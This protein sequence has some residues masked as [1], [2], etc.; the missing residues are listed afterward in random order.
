MKLKNIR[1]MK[2]VKGSVLLTVICVM[3][4]MLIIVTAT[5][6][7]AANASNRAYTSYMKNQATYT[8]RSAVNATIAKLSSDPNGAMS[9]EII[10]LLKSGPVELTVSDVSGGFGN[11]DRIVI[12][13]TGKLDDETGFYITGSKEKIYK[14]TAH[15][16]I[17][18]KEQTFSQYVT[19]KDSGGGGGGGGTGITCFG[20]NLGGESTS[21]TILGYY[22][23]NVDGVVSP[24]NPFGLE[25]EYMRNNSAYIGGKFFNSNVEANV[26]ATFYLDAVE[27]GPPE[28]VTIM[29]N[30]TLG[31]DS[32]SFNSNH[33]I[34]L[35]KS[36]GVNKTRAE[37]VKETPYLYV[38]GTLSQKSADVNMG[39]VDYPVNLYVG[40]FQSD[41][42]QLKKLN[43]SGDMYIYDSTES[44]I[45]SDDGSNLIDWYT[46]ASGADIGGSLYSKGDVKFDL[47]GKNFIINGDLCVDGKITVTGGTLT[48]KGTCEVGSFEIATGAK[49]TDGTND[50][51]PVIKTKITNFPTYME[52]SALIANEVIKTQ[53]NVKDEYY[54][55][56]NGVKK[57]KGSKP[58]ADFPFI[59]A[60]LV[61]EYT[62]N[63]SNQLQLNGVVL[64]AG[65]TVIEEDCIIKGKITGQ[66]LRFKPAE[67]GGKIKV[68]L[69]DVIFDVTDVIVE[70]NVYDSTGK[71]ISKATVEF[72]IA[73]TDLKD[74]G[75][76]SMAD[77][78]KFTILGT[79]SGVK[80]VTDY[81]D[82]KIQSGKEID[83]FPLIAG[84][85]GLEAVPY[86]NIYGPND[87]STD[88][89]I[90]FNNQT[91]FSGLI[92]APK[93]DYTHF[94]G[95]NKVILPYKIKNGK[96]IPA[97]DIKNGQD[98]A[99]A[100][101]TPSMGVRNIVQ[102]ENDCILYVIHTADD[103]V[104]DVGDPVYKW[105]TVGG[106]ADY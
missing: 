70:D 81:Y 49:I 24:T 80:F 23:S 59:D 9:K 53:Q 87:T 1:Y 11:I 96:I 68:L 92:N 82:K 10:D 103:D 28:G 64:P 8:A 86:I 85:E 29:G 54:E 95:Y 27:N 21:A 31:N 35:E 69:S 38:N 3:F 50:I 79:G 36:P 62:C 14:I 43:I 48:V 74:N 89:K 2:K 13:D 93:A 51:T 65:E 39:S 18:G 72:Y 90:I 63:N 17:G 84:R 19:S 42:S 60:I 4:V 73:T 100:I 46:G 30:L 61:D 37:L 99:I 12:S 40:N 102:L 98:K 97:D 32:P 88:M 83:G 6:T 16:T 44:F 76:N 45:R 91:V 67:N 26:K 41:P 104:I 66:K 5:L 77:E 47:P 33:I 101:I 34:A 58:M 94:N 52:K 106:F 56:V 25:Y 105:S 55:E 20:N 57:V 78:N 71:F 7:L 75:G 15:T 22:T